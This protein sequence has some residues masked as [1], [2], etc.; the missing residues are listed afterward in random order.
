MPH[1]QKA[2]PA[3]IVGKRLHLILCIFNVLHYFLDPQILQ[4]DSRNQVLKRKSLPSPQSYAT[5]TTRPL[6]HVNK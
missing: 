6:L 5:G 1:P 2:T 4:D 3:E